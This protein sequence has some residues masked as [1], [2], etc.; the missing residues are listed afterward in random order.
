MD[1]IE[2]GCDAVVNCD[3]MIDNWDAVVDNCNAV[4]DSNAMVGCVDI[5]TDSK[6][7]RVSDF[8]N[9]SGE[10]NTAECNVRLIEVSEENIVENNRQDEARVGIMQAKN[11]DFH[12]YLY[13]TIPEITFPTRVIKIPAFHV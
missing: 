7:G 8:Y 10:Q 11:I 1:E 3:C 12:Q 9:S 13:L 5:Q 6:A 4:V 2:D